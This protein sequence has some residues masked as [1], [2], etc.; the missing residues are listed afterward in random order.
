MLANL[1]CSIT[2]SVCQISDMCCLTTQTPK[3]WTVVFEK[4]NFLSGCCVVAF[5]HARVPKGAY[6][7]WDHSKPWARSQ[8]A[9]ELPVK[10]R[11]S[12]ISLNRIFCSQSDFNNF[13]TPRIG[14]QEF[15][16]YKIFAPNQNQFRMFC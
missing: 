4:I 2:N 11:V 1:I 15:I 10:P 14:S 16:V 3:V 7:N 6:Q 5:D 12:K 9:S 8:L 13:Q